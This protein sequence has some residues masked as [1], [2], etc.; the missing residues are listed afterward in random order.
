M[1]DLG[2][3][4]VSG[5]LGSGANTVTYDAQD[6][7]QRCAVKVIN[8]DAVPSDPALRAGLVR[9]LSGL[10]ALEHPS[11][12]KVLAAG[13]EGG[14]LY[15]ATEFMESPT[16]AQKIEGQPPMTEG[17]VVLFVRQAAQALDK[18][19]DQGYCHGSLSA[20]N[21]FV[22]SEEKI[23]LVDF[24]IESL[25]A[26]P[27]NVDEMG[28]EAEESDSNMDEWVTAEDLL[29][30]KGRKA[31]VGGL[32]EDFTGLAVLMLQMLGVSVPP[33]APGQGIGDYRTLLLRDVYVGLTDPDS[34]VSSQTSE[35]VR[36]LLTDE[37]FG[38]P[39][40]VVVE[41][42]SAMLLGRSFGRTRPTP[43][44]EPASATA[45]AQV[46][47]TQPPP[48]PPETPADASSELDFQMPAI[49]LEEPEPDFSPF[50]VWSDRHS[51]RFFVIHEGEELSI[52]RDPDVCDVTLMDSAVSRK[53]CI[54]SRTG[55]TV[56]IEDNGSSNGTFINEERVH[57]AEVH[58]GDRLRI[59]TTRVYL[60]LPGRG[61]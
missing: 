50:F 2:R 59:G 57:N 44:V 37:G 26:N 11:A 38:S 42:A 35:V 12:V 23:K 36:R 33:A 43:A 13:E 27:P 4:T 28:A 30:S 47:A 8:D 1:E 32:D 53:H 24:A 40:E 52:G 48:A 41:L 31:S 54:L 10:A 14:K 15:V 21:V 39:G 6:G 46:R 51:G 5:E 18:A 61:K 29:R 34:G 9:A 3:Y 19:R 45:T 7:N 16:L 49:D 58:V 60:S 20:D 56:R 55:S 25:I 17:Q 22:V